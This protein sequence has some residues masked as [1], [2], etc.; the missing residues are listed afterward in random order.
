M[1]FNPISTQ[2]YDRM[3]KQ[4]HIQG[5]VFATGVVKISAMGF[6]IAGLSA[7][8]AAAAPTI[9]GSVEA[10]YNY[11]LT[12]PTDS[13][14]N[15]LHS[16]DAQ[17]KTFTVNNAHLVFSGSDSA[18]GLAYNVETD[19]G[20]DAA[21]NRATARIG[22]SGIT[23]VTNDPSGYDVDLQEAY[24]TWAFGPGKTFG[25]KAG[26]YVTYQGIEVVEGGANPTVTRGLLFGLAEPISHTGLEV[27]DVIGKVDVHAG[28]VN[29]C[30]AFNDNN[31]RP[32]VVAKL[33]LNLGDPLALTVSTMWGP[34][35]AGNN[36]NNRLTFDATG[37]TKLVPMTD[38]WFQGIYGM[39]DKASA[40]K[41]GDDASWFGFGVQP[42]VHLN[43]WFAL[44]LRYEFFSDADRAR[45][46]S[47]LSNLG[48]EK[49]LTVQNVSIAPTVN[50]TKSTMVRAEFRMDFASNDIFKDSDNKFTGSQMEV[51]ADW[52]TNF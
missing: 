52:V 3:I 44:G 35:A 13:N 33:G 32:S 19:F 12:I 38:L 26:K 25:L 42:L 50:L 18:T 17:S 6:A 16:Y 51:A 15:F 39:E 48:L 4:S 37:I 23:S 14:K 21:V 1:G 46:S 43:A 30:D 47:T 28:L 9:S 41:T 24:V 27:S 20:S 31:T 22:A 29:G 5:K 49:D 34:E 2:E 36:D 40:V 8:R 45:T 10:G 7:S 11:N